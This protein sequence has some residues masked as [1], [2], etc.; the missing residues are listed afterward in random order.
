MSDTN[1]NVTQIS[2]SLLTEKERTYC[3]SIAQS[4]EGLMNKRAAALLALDDGSTRAEA[5]E[6][7][8][9]TLGQVRYLLATFRQKRLGMFTKEALMEMEEV[10]QTEDLIPKTELKEEAEVD[11]APEIKEAKSGKK[12][13]KTSE[14]K[15]KD[16]R[17]KTKKKD[18]KTKKRKGSKV[19]GK[20]GKGKKGKAKKGKGK[21]SKEK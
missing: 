17:K 20:K 15:V 6:R 16:K 19:K 10:P 7:S 2:D 3:Q 18:K 5:G 14:K 13:K 12:K 9:L 4:G 21:A 8:G 1:E 11:K